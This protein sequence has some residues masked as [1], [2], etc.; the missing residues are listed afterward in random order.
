MMRQGARTGLALVAALACLVAPAC[1][2][3]PEGE[4]GEPA[5]SPLPPE[6]ATLVQ[7]TL[8][9]EGERLLSR[10]NPRVLDKAEFDVA[11]P[12]DHE[13]TVVLGCYNQGTIGILRVDR[14][15]LARVMEVTAAHEMLHAAYLALP[16]GERVEVDGW[17][18]EYYVTVD[19]RDI[20]ELVG[21]YAL[22]RSDVRLNE[23]HSIL[24]TELP[25]LSP[26]LETYYGRY[27]ADRQRVVQAHESYAAVFRD[28]KRRV[29]S[30]HA[31]IDSYK[32]ELTSLDSR[33]A[34]RKAQLDSLNVRL[35][36][37]R[38]QGN[39]RS[40]N[41]LIPQQNALVDEYNGLIDEYNQ[42]VDLHNRKV[43]EVNAL[44]L[45]Q[46]ELATS[47]GSKPSLPASRP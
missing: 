18:E 5:A 8:T 30:L 28:I 12:F 36:Q 44:A 37:L 27:F 10:A 38:V 25:V 1:G 6:V 20:R 17:I 29:A 45:E 15:E 40:Y 3:G 23:L 43:D 39:L 22:Q 24:A 4:A 41:S 46:D 26:Q 34:S 7:G 33:I 13:L 2:G 42:T 14:P 31:E 32:A 11:C 35:D 21:Q 9:R 19:D 16:H 47:L